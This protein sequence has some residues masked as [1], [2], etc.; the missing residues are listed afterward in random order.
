MGGR[1]LGMDIMILKGVQTHELPGIFQAMQFSLDAVPT[2]VAAVVPEPHRLLSAPAREGPSRLAG[3]SGGMTGHASSGESRPLNVHVNVVNQSVTGEKSGGA[4]AKEAEERIKETGAALEMIRQQT[5]LLPGILDKVEA[6]PQRTVTLLEVQGRQ[7]VGPSGNVVEEAFTASAHFTNLCWEGRQYVL[8]GKAAAIIEALYL[9][10]K[11]YE[12]PGFQQDEV[13]GQIYGGDK[14][15]W[16]AGNARIQNFFRL[17]DAKRL[18]D[19][20]FVRHDGRGNFWLDVKI[21]TNT[22]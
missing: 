4:A 11:V 8:R 6:T 14:K 18:W 7:K 19:D 12:L 2:M 5:E 3:C 10:R 9:A 20:G 13:F 22:H 15:K 1:R 17:G 21:H 16:P